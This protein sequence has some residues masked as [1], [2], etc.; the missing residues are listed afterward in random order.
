M[1]HDRIEEGVDHEGD[2]DGEPYERRR[3]MQDEIVEGEKDGLEAVVLNAISHRAEAIEQLGS[4]RRERTPI[5]HILSR[6]EALHAGLFP[7]GVRHVRKTVVWSPSCVN[8]GAGVRRQER[9][10]WTRRVDEVFA[11]G[12]R[13]GDS[14]VRSILAILW[15]SQQCLSRTGREWECGAPSSGWPPVSAL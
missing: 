15:A 5:R 12:V 2:E 8:G 11:I 10:S 14:R 13:F 4:H 9:V 6:C 7:G 3:H 1:A